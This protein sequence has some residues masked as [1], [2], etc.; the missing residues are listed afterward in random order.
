MLV[1]QNT[2]GVL[3][4]TRRDQNA[5]KKN[6]STDNIIGLR[7]NFVSRHP[8][9]LKFIQTGCGNL[10]GLTDKMGLII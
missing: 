10:R 2:D 5:K 4:S 8:P 3:I 6:N 9:Q 1:N 7:D